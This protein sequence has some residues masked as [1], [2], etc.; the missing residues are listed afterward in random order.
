MTMEQWTLEG[1]SGHEQRERIIIIVF[2]AKEIDIK[3]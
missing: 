2:G 3:P 1:L